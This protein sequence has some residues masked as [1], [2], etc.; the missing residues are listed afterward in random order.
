MDVP[1]ARTS[2]VRL[3]KLD[4]FSRLSTGQSIQQLHTFLAK[5]QLT[6][7]CEIVSGSLPQRGHTSSTVI[8]FFL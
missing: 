3:E 2:K 1:L 6:K 8:P 7:E 4:Q 5:S